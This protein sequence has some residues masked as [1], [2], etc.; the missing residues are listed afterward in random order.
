MTAR[1]TKRAVTNNE[2]NNYRLKARKRAGS[3]LF[4][5]GSLWLPGQQ[6]G[7]SQTMKSTIINWRREKGRAV[8]FLHWVLHDCPGSKEGSRK[9]WN[10]QLSTEGEKKGGQSS[11]YIEFFMTARVAKRAVANNEINIYQLKAGKK[12]GS[13][14]FTSGDSWL[15]ALDRRQ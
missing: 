13:H 1:V 15:P 4:T 2:I 11:F 6:R 7:Q 9:Q 8:I 3:H 5:L 12:E 14:L 10:Q